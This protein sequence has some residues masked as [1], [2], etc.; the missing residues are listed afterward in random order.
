MFE[1]PVRN[2]KLLCQREKVCTEGEI[3]LDGIR[4]WCASLR[5]DGTAY[6]SVEN[7]PSFLRLDMP[8]DA[9]K[10]GNP[11]RL[12]LC[13]LD[14]LRNDETF[15]KANESLH[16]LLCFTSVVRDMDHQA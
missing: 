1:F 15:Q 10:E 4:W 9:L 2:A 13:S 7:G 12:E 3:R 14:L 8:P 6:I 11:G 5:Q 16:A